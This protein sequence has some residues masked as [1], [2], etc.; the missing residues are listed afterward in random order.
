MKSDGPFPFGG[1]SSAVA[2]HRMRASGKRDLG[3]NKIRA[4]IVATWCSLGKPQALGHGSG[5]AALRKSTY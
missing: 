2:K 5:T 3:H 1:R 4:D